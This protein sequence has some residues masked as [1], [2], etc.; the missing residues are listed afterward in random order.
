[1]P[2]QMNPYFKAILVIAAAVLG[3]FGAAMAAHA[4]MAQIYGSMATAAG[5]A[6]LGLFTNMPK[7]EWSEE[8]RAVKLGGTDEKVN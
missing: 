7:R 5:S 8:E 3:A 4:D 1:M 2:Q 6:I